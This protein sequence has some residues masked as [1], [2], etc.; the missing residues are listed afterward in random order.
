MNSSSR[1][2]Y[3]GCELLHS[4]QHSTMCQTIGFCPPL[5]GVTNPKYKLLCFSTS[6]IFCKEKKAPAFNQDMCCH[7]ALCLQLILF[8][9]WLKARVLVYGRDESLINLLVQNVLWC[10]ASCNKS[11]Q[12]LKSEILNIQYL[13]TLWF[14]SARG[15]RYKTLFLLQCNPCK[16]S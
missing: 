13:Q 5:D 8:H 7:L 6:N 16:R 4:L 2:S 14:T 9:C 15:N 3:S 12:K 11:P 1:M 10:L